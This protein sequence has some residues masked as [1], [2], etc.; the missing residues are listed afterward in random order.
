M[1][2]MITQTKTKSSELHAKAMDTIMEMARSGRIINFYT[3]AK[4]AGVS[5]AFLYAHSDLA[6]MIHTCRITH[7]SKQDLQ[8][9]VLLLRLKAQA[10]QNESEEG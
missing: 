9:E 6:A 3:V 7:M 2:N 4:E 8:K 1:E 10:T 5:R